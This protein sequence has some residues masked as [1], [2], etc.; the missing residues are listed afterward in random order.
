MLLP[1]PCNW[2]R[3]PSSSLSFGP[4]P[5]GSLR[6]QRLWGHLQP[7]LGHQTLGITSSPFTKGSGLQQGRKQ[8]AA[9]GLPGVSAHTSRSPL[10]RRL[11]SCHQV[12]PGTRCVGN[13]TFCSNTE[14]GNAD[15]PKCP[16]TLPA[17]K[18]LPPP[19]PF[20]ILGLASSHWVRRI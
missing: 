7:Q 17:G 15:F 18:N 11:L 8:E 13:P 19:W 14:L 12:P 16:T 5:Q 1:L 10:P 3:S 9:R 6:C 20:L 4:L 2:P